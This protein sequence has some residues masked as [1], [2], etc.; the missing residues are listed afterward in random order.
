MKKS[1]APLPE[2]VCIED[3]DPENEKKLEVVEKDIN[4]ITSNACTGGFIFSIIITVIMIFLIVS[5]G[6]WGF[7]TIKKAIPKFEP[8]ADFNNTI[9]DWG[10]KPFVEIRVQSYPCDDRKDK[11]EPV[12][13]RKWNGTD[14]GYDCSGEVSITKKN[15]N[16]KKIMNTTAF[17]QTT[18]P[19]HANPQ[20][21]A[22][23]HNIAILQHSY[24]C[25]K[26][27]GDPF[28]KVR[29]AENGKCPKDTYPCSEKTTG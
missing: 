1:N 12:F 27:G 20:Y 16:C 7:K 24:I 8:T 11:W 25:G 5:E 22:N 19:S 28:L 14:I 6:G 10:R 17:N 4:D 23:L 18:F 2:I 9:F 15:S 13:E 21:K 3:V 29:R 26:R